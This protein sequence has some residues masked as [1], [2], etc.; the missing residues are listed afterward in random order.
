MN[1]ESAESFV[2]KL[3]EIK[4]LFWWK[5]PR[6]ESSAMFGILFKKM[7]VFSSKKMI[8]RFMLE[9][10]LSDWLRQTSLQMPTLLWSAYLGRKKKLTARY[11]INK[12][13]LLD[14][15]ISTRSTRDDSLDIY[16]T[17]EEYS[18]FKELWNQFIRGTMKKKIKN[19]NIS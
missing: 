14:E 6:A 3:T 17:R 7:K 18:M 10:Q 16:R 15:L 4:S 19:I 2:K 12:R 1:M 9:A 13:W 5:R 11:E 8:N